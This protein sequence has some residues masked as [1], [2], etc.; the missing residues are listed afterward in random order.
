MNELAKIAANTG[1]ARR[2]GGIRVYG[3]LAHTTPVYVYV[4]GPREGT[5]IKIGI[6]AQDSVEK[7]LGQLQASHWVTLE[8]H[9]A[10]RL[11]STVEAVDFEAALHARFHDKCIRGEW[12]AITA[13]EA[14]RAIRETLAHVRCHFEWVTP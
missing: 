3:D 4:F 6:T 12:F 14:H 10:V 8:L 5:P 2:V 1:R 13:D 7:R 11:H 9:A